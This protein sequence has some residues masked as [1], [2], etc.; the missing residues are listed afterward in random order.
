M[1]DPATGSMD[2]AESASPL[3]VEG[4][5]VVEGD[6][7]VTPA[8]VPHAGVRYAVLRVALLVTVGG[9]LYVVGMRG[10]PLLFAAVLASGVL[11]F[12]VFVRQREAAARNLEASLAARAERRHPHDGTDEGADIDRG[13]ESAGSG[14]PAEPI[15]GAAI[16]ADSSSQPID[17][18]GTGPEAPTAP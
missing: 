9:V 3:P 1:N 7:A 4:A 6:E 18:A 17:D 5:S 15:D 8:V 16:G 2:A 12:F 10:W 13:P 14:R 11:S